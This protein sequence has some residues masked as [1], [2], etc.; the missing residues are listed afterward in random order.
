MK[1]YYTHRARGRSLISSG[2]HLKKWK[3]QPKFRENFPVGITISFWSLTVSL[4]SRPHAQ[5]PNVSTQRPSCPLLWDVQ[6]HHLDYCVC[7][8]L[9]NFCTRGNPI[10]ICAALH[11]P[12]FAD[13]AAEFHI[14]RH[15]DIF[16][17]L[18]CS[19]S[20][21]LVHM[22]TST[23][24]TSSAIRLPLICLKK[25]CG[26]LNQGFSSTLILPTAS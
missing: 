3:A 22:L 1:S 10:T 14:E 8:C 19:R 23:W 18:M 6:F 13:G 9:D 26:P 16:A 21:Q 24:N 25:W 7:I 15:I 12:T 5:S 17:L 4:C 20:L 11:K 2:N